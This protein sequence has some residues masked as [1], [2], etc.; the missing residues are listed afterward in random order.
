MYRQNWTPQATSFAFAVCFCSN[1][2]TLFQLTTPEKSG[3]ALAK[4]DSTIKKYGLGR[5]GSKF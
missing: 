5:I 2:T 4:T 1:W 3:P